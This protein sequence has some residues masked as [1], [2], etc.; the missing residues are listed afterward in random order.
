[1]LPG[2]CRKQ[3][4]ALHNTKEIEEHTQATPEALTTDTATTTWIMVKLLK[5]VMV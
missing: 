3:N 5:K 1:M 2:F 4:N